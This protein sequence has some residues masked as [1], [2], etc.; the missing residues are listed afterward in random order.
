[1]NADGGASPALRSVRGTGYKPIF[2][3]RRDRPMQVVFFASGGPGNLRAA[4]D[5]ADELPEL[6][7]VG[8]VVTDRPAIPSIE[9]AASRGIPFIT[10]CFEDECGRWAD[11][12]GDAA[13]ESRYRAAA[14]SFHDRMLGLIRLEEERRG[15]PFDLAVLAYRRW[16]HGSLLRYFEERMINQHPGDLSVMSADGLTRRYIGL[17]PVM[18]ALSAGERRTRTSTFVVRPGP[19]SGEILCQGPW[20]EFGRQALTREA[21]RAHENL[22]KE[23][24]DW[25]SL[26]AAL[27]GI[28]R[29][30]FGLALEARHPDGNKVVIFDGVDQP[31]SGV[32]LNPTDVLFKASAR[33]SSP[34]SN[35]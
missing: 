21:A 30:A 24:S 2:V 23:Q 4:L 18:A 19:D 8:L 10:R 12:R 3:P 20:A 22:Q 9:L 28:A 33:H 7:R 14:E 16:I 27:V 15:A 17:D 6:I 32:G 11:A 31:Y 29:G 13:R 34:H 1:M 35:I 26:K 5:V 25:P